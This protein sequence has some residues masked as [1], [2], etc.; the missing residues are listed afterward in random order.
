MPTPPI[1]AYTAR[2]IAE[3]TTQR[4]HP[5]LMNRHNAATNRS[6]SVK[7]ST[8][9]QAKFIN[10]SC[11]SRGRVPR[12][13]IKTAIDINT[14]E[15]NQNQDGTHPRNAKG[16]DHPPR[17]NVVPNPEIDSIPTYSPRKNSANLNPEY[18]VKYPATSSDS[19]S[20]RSNGERLVSAV[21]A[22]AYIRKAA[23]PQGVKMYQCG[24]PQVYWF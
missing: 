16:A 23:S 19:P 4:A 17:N 11:L 18:S 5:S 14:L 20:G 13:Q 15:K 7:G 2:R 12:I 3:Q 6:S 21:A 24:R 1:S 22:M 9:F 10:W 8:N